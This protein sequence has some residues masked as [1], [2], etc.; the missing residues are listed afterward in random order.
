MQ[1]LGS[2]GYLGWLLRCCYVVARLPGVVAKWLLKYPGRLLGF[3]YVVA[4]LPRAVAR[5]FL[6]G[7]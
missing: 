2:L 4:R 6:C 3:C 5:E 1:L 7:C